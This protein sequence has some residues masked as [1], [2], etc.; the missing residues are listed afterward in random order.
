MR[1]CWNSFKALGRIQPQMP[2][3]LQPAEKRPSRGNSPREGLVAA[4]CL[5][6]GLHPGEV[7][8]Q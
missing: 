6:F 3:L 8:F 1:V 7:T 4:G 2:F 5:A